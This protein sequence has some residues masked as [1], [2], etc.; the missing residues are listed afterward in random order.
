MD[1]FYYDD[2][3]GVTPFGPAH[4]YNPFAL[5]PDVLLSDSG[6]LSPLGFS[7]VHGGG[8]GATG[9]ASLHSPS[10]TLVSATGSN[11]AI[12]LVW[13]TSVASA[14]SGFTSAVIA[15]A[16]ALV[17]DLT[18]PSRTV[19]YV[20]VGWGEIAGQAMAANALGESESTGYLTNYTTVANALHADG[21]TLNASNE[22]TTGQFFV[23]SA[24]A[25]ALGL[26]SRTG[27]STTS[28]D[29]YVGFSSLTGT[30]YSWQ[31]G[32]TGTTASQ[33]NLQA[34]VQH[35][36]T[37]VMGRISM[38]GT[39]TYNGHK[40]YTPLDLFDFS[41]SGTLALSNT[42]GYFSSNGGATDMGN[43]NDAALYGGD[44]GDWASYLSA[45]Q[46]GTLSSGEDPFDAFS[47]PGYD[48]TL[49]G[50]DLFEMAALGDPLTAAGQ[51][52]A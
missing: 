10:P 6:A 39:V 47:R 51:A 21:Y 42:G 34:V 50:D 1:N 3:F 46:S 26:V 38:E 33:F 14:P 52:L 29:G 23:A 44:I 8:G 30:G 35:E 11:L 28:V 5:G 24:E 12:D 13:D 15:A 7:S 36:L 16:Q 19:L 43:F 32:A 25:K 40:T 2:L 18:E 41:A 48:L 45:S 4:G 22:P 20:A 17:S 37:E 49:S 27:G 31:Y 9:G